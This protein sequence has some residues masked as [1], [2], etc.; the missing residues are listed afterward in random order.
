MGWPRI[1]RWLT[2]TEEGGGS[3]KAGS[4]A[5][6]RQ[7]TAWMARGRGRAYVA[8]P[9]PLAR[10]RAVLAGWAAKREGVG[11][12]GWAGREEKRKGGSRRENGFLF[13]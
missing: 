8:L 9:E 11:V 3:D 5:A 2:E 7:A 10:P 6:T 13:S 1:V 4:A 12:A